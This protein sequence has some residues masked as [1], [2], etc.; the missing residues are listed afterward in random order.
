MVY[1][2][3]VF[4]ALFI[5]I[6]IPT[7]TLIRSKTRLLTPIAWVFRSEG[8]LKRLSAQGGQVFSF[9]IVI[10]IIKKIQNL[11]LFC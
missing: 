9:A 10:T 5:V 7:H 8:L 6:Q 11:V 4:G 3:L 1:F 2:I